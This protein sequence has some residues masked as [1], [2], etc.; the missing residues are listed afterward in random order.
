M[1]MTM[2]CSAERAPNSHRHVIRTALV[3]LFETPVPAS[4]KALREI[5]TRVLHNPDVNFEQPIFDFTTNDHLRILDRGQGI[6]SVVWETKEKKAA[7]AQS[8][9]N[10][11]VHDGHEVVVDFIGTCSF[12]LAILWIVLIQAWQPI[13]SWWMARRASTP[14]SSPRT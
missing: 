8:V 7:N 2:R 12:K 14:P 6:Q 10:P 9:L 3:A 1:A 11:I 13:S 5:I 4:S